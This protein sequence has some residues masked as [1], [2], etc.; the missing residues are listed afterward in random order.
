MSIKKVLEIA[1]MVMQRYRVGDMGV[2]P[3][4]TNRSN[5]RKRIIRELRLEKSQNVLRARSCGFTRNDSNINK[6]AGVVRSNDGYAL[7][8]I[9]GLSMK[10]QY[11]IVNKLKKIL[12]D[13]AD[14]ERIFVYDGPYET[15]AL[16]MEDYLHGE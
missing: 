13:K 3:V 8:D 7:L 6:W 11:D 5:K 16:I 10:Y 9:S 1:V 2:S 15:S 12:P 14:R 4:N